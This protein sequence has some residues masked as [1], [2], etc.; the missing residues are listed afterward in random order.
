[1]TRPRPGHRHLKALPPAHRAASPVTVR[2]SVTITLTASQVRLLGFLADR[3]EPPRAVRHSNYATLQ[4]Q[5][6]I[7]LHGDLAKY[8]VTALGQRAIQELAQ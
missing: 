7:Y 5:G 8:R 1:M 3:C 6:L 2:A 4:A